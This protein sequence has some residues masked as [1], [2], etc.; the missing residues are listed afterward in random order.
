MYT[1]VTPSH[2]ASRRPWTAALFDDALADT[3]L[4]FRIISRHLDERMLEEIAAAYRRGRLLLIG[5]INLDAGVPVIWN[6]G[7]I[8]ALGHPRAFETVRKVLLTFSAV[9][10]AF[11][12]VL[13]EGTVD[14]RTYQ[15]LHVV[16]G[17]WRSCSSTPPP[18][19]PSAASSSPPTA[20]SRRCAH[21]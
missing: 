21:G 1:R 4:L 3:T 6:V 15:E 8:A 9:P 10:G 16:G 7:G 13:F 11:P 14:G 17:L 20:G 12:P 18:S 19:G 2:I 5:T